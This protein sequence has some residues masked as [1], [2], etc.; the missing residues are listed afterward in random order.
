[1]KT[2]FPWKAPKSPMSSQSG[3]TK[4]AARAAAD[5]TYITERLAPAVDL[6]TS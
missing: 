2:A 1:M 3:D 6:V 5:G 4:G